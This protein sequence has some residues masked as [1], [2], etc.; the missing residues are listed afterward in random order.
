MSS[1]NGFHFIIDVSAGAGDGN[2]RLPRVGYD[3]AGV[4]ASVVADT[5]AAG[6]YAAAN[7]FDWKPYTYWKPLTAGTQYVTIIPA[8][9][10]DVNYFA[11]A[12]HNI[13]NNG[14]TIELEYS[15]NSGSTWISATGVITPVSNETVWRSFTT[16]TA[17][18]WR[19]KVTS[20]PVSVLGTV[21]FGAVYQPYYGQL[22]GFT[23]P[24]L[25]RDTEIYSNGSEGGNFLGRSVLRRHVKTSITL[26]N[27]DDDDMYNDWLP[28]VKHAER[29]P[30]FFAWNYEDRASDVAL[31]Q[32]DGKIPAP[33]FMRHG[34]MSVMLPMRGLSPS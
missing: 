18:H 25:G 4:G 28:F 8:S 9:T 6:A 1:G 31:M 7:L 13:G 16:I 15:L 33:T 19:I 12:Q 30:F 17:S 2:Q 14:G 10:P 5:T 22:E 24:L 23:P 26:M 11:F 27:M 20:T 32:S 29:Y 21:S 34:I 3:N